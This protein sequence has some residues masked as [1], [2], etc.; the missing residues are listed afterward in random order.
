[1]EFLIGILLGATV[2]IV[3]IQTIRWIPL[4]ETRLANRALAWERGRNVLSILEPRVTRAALGL[5]FQ[6]VGN[7]LM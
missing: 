3:T 1:V 2:S 7:V 4:T 6:Q 5:T